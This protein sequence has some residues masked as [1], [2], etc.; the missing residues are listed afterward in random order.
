METRCLAKALLTTSS[1]SGLHLHVQ[2]YRELKL[3]KTGIKIIFFN[4]VGFDCRSVRQLYGN[5]QVGGMKV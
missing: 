4:S 5:L 1:S 3:A 2:I